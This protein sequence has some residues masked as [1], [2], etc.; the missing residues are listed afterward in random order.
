MGDNRVVHFAG[1]NA[2]SAFVQETSLEDF[3]LGGTLCIQEYHSQE[4]PVVSPK[5]AVKNAKL[6][7][8]S[9]TGCYDLI[10]FNCE[11]IATWCK[12]GTFPLCAQVY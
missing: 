8:G 9:F 3:L 4:M 6:L 5:T 2:K 7:L 12:T 1:S 10:H 11:H